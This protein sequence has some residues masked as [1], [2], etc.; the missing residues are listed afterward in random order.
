MAIEIVSFPIENDDFPVRKLLVYQRV[1]KQLYMI[2]ESLYPEH[3]WNIS[4][5]I[6]L[7]YTRYLIVRQLCQ[8]SVVKSSI[9][10]GLNNFDWTTLIFA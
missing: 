7:I 3:S 9:L 6:I 4:C 8:D 2:R 1:W 10:S 5:Y